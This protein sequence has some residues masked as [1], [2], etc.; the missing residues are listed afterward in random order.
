[1]YILMKELN[2][3]VINK[4]YIR[5]FKIDKYYTA[6]FLHALPTKKNTH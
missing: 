5:L 6:M 3:T 1:M 2:F 4:V